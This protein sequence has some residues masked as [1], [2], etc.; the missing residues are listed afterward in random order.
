[1]WILEGEE[2][3]QKKIKYVPGLYKI[4]D[5]IIVN[6]ADNYQRDKKMTK[7]EVNIVREEISV[8]NDGL[9]IPVQI[10]KTHKVYIPELIFGHLL[11]SSNY[12]D[13]DKKVT[14]GRN[15]FGAK[16]ANLFSTHFSIE[17][18]DSANQ[19]KFVLNWTNNMTS[20]G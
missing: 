3:V 8:L 20:M 18:A 13:S 17:A 19:K 5:E 7:I 9:S 14:G 11:T 15:G 2:V 6:A 1:M 12:D 4:F 10:H 16:L